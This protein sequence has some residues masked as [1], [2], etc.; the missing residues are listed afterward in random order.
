M[1]FKNVF[2]SAFPFISAA[3][4]A[5]GPLGTM[6]ANAI[7]G[8]LGLEKITPDAIPDA[9]AA[10]AADPDKM[11]RLR[12]SE[13]Q[14]KL[15]MAQFGFDSVEKLEEI[16]AQDRANARAREITVKDKTPRNIAYIVVAATIIFEGVI[17][18][19]GIAAGI[20]PVI[21]GRI[22]GTLDLA[23][24]LVLGYFYGSSASSRAKD[25]TIHQVLTG[26]ELE[27]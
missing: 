11:L 2:K 7:G 17:L 24:G 8:A 10:A 23:L 27:H 19:H 25:S 16:A 20:D 21:T 14:F 12:D 5:G 13:Q 22:L 9:I 3:A 4:S 15:Q 26:D 6:A 18:F 1:N